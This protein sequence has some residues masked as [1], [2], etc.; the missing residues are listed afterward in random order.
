MNKQKVY[1]ETS[2]ISYLTA[3]P[4]RD[5]IIAA[6]QKIT[7]DWWHKYKHQFDCFI[8]QFVIDEVSKGDSLAASKRL[9]SISKLPSLDYSPL[10]DDLAKNYIKLFG[11][12]EKSKLDAY[13]LSIAV[14]FEMDYLLSWNCKH[15][16]NAVISNKINDY[17]SKHSL[18]IP[19]LC[20]PLSLMEN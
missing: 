14:I 3:K 11:F 8:S 7:Y 15:I 9:N 13:H 2:V 12:P 4:S 5:L 6:H 17:N 18:F 1:I 19:V 10:I 20:T 16:S